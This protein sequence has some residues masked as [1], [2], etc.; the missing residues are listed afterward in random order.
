MRCVLD[1][2]ADVVVAEPVRRLGGMCENK[3][4]AGR[5]MAPTGRAV[6]FIGITI[7]EQRMT[8]A[9]I[10]PVTLASVG[11]RDVMIEQEVR[12]GRAMGPTGRTQALVG[13]TVEE[14]HPATFAMAP[15]CLAYCT[16]R[17]ISRQHKPIPC[18]LMSRT[19]P[20]WCHRPRTRRDTYRSTAS[21]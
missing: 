2:D 1:R 19:G 3:I 17:A 5:G 6:S 4:P 9:A 20:Y 13:V 8:L 14:Q 12:R 7:K 10:P 18:R 16:F 15:V 11:G 21:R